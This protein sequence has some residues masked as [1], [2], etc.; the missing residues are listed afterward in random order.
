MILVE[1][2][3]TP[4]NEEGA[5]F[6][7]S[8]DAEWR[9]DTGLTRLTRH[10][11]TKRWR[12]HPYFPP[13]EVREIAEELSKMKRGAPV[14]DRY[15]YVEITEAMHAPPAVAPVVA[16]PVPSF[17]LKT[18]TASNA[19]PSVSTPTL[20]SHTPIAHMTAP[21]MPISATPAKLTV[22]LPQSTPIAAAPSL[23]TPSTPLAHQ[24]TISVPSTPATP[25][26]P[27]QTP[28]GGGI[29]KFKFG[30]SA[31]K[32][33]PIGEDASATPTSAAAATPSTG[34]KFV[35]SAPSMVP[36]AQPVSASLNVPTVAP[37]IPSATT[38]PT[39]TTTAPS[40]GN[41]TNP[42]AMA[43]DVAPPPSIPTESSAPAPSANSAEYE[44]KLN[45]RTQ[46]ARQ[47]VSEEAQLAKQIANAQNEKNVMM[48]KRMQQSATDIQA[49]IK[50]LEE[51]IAQLDQALQAFGV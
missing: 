34:P 19:S 26:T 11:R 20:T 1:D 42:N 45:Q 14:P 49:R 28:S 44:M 15:E 13:H 41:F 29:F 40:I 27:S 38:M 6:K 35:I 17:T 25:A 18:S 16:K 9:L 46:L 21:E 2:P 33:A 3:Y 51:Q 4:T 8:F 22:S 31:K 48:K 43:V 5:P 10:I 39:T 47:K 12:R 32:A 24:G 36:A 23:M 37:T 50:K 30:S 7:A